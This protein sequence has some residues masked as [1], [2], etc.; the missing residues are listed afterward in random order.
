MCSA[1]C[2]RC[3][4]R[5][6]F[7]MSPSSAC[8]YKFIDIYANTFCSVSARPSHMRRLYELSA[9]P[10]KIWRPLP[11]GDHNASFLEEGYFE[12]I[13]DFISSMTFDTIAIG[14]KGRI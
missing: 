1:G 10:N 13:S 6:Y 5:S 4:M 12:A 8:I 9:A 2:I 11:A 7:C 3:E 14:E